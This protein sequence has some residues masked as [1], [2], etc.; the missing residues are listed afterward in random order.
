MVSTDDSD[1]CTMRMGQRGMSK[2]GGENRT[3][4]GEALKEKGMAESLSSA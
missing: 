2:Q 3:N 4:S 1:G